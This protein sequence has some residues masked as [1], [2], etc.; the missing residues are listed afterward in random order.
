MS[1]V[2]QALGPYPTSAAFGRA[3]EAPTQKRQA[4]AS[5]ALTVNASIERW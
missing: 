1:L 5:A 4:L 2:Q 3:K